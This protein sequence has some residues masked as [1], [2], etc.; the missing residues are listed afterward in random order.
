M[1]FFCSTCLFTCPPEIDT[2]VELKSKTGFTNMMAIGMLWSLVRQLVVVL[3]FTEGLFESII[4]C[5]FHWMKKTKKKK[6]KVADSREIFCSLTE[7]ESRG[8][9]RRNRGPR[10]TYDQARLDS[11]CDHGNTRHILN[12]KKKKIIS[13]WTSIFWVFLFF[14]ANRVSEITQIFTNRPP[15]QAN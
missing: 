3:S 5:P 6:I 1:S 10:S 7:E 15:W 14:L 4:T 11:Q 12:L 9:N 13:F 2:W 8:R